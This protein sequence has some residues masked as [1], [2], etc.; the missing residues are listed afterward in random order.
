MLPLSR[1]ATGAYRWNKW[2]HTYGRHTTFDS[3]SVITSGEKRLLDHNKLKTVGEI[4][5]INGFSK[6]MDSLMVIGNH[7]NEFHGIIGVVD[8]LF[9]NAAGNAEWGYDILSNDNG[10]QR[11]RMTGTT[12]ITQFPW[13]ELDHG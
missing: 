6:D 1:H 2:H 10:Y 4:S 3:R 13:Q 5:R 9:K 11:Q 12:W 8:I 7:L